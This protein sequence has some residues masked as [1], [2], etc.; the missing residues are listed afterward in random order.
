MEYRLEL[1]QR[2]LERH[3]RGRPETCLEVGPGTG[4]FSALLARRS[5]SLLLFDL[6]R[7]MLD[8]SRTSL[9]GR[10]SRR[11]TIQFVQGSLEDLPF[12]SAIFDRVVVLGVLAFVARD[13]GPVLMRLGQLLRPNGRILFEI[14]TPTQDTMSI[15]PASP[16]AAKTILREPSRYHLW[17]VVRRGYQPFDP[18]HFARFE[19]AWLRPPYLARTVARAG[20]RVVDQMAIGPNFGNQPRLLKRLRRTAR[21]Y[22]NALRLEEETGRWPELF[23]AGA[24]LLVAAGQK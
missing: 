16:A 1:I 6:S 8:A 10:P 15:L 9:R 4:R 11:P 17:S 19:V 24:G 5:R 21:A 2:F 3:L 22:S 20:L 13:I 23:G 18:P 7:P 12:H 14:R